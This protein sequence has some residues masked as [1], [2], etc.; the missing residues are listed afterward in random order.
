MIRTSVR[1]IAELV[2]ALGAVEGDRILIHSAVFAFGLIEDGLAG[3]HRGI[4]SVVGAE[5]TIIVPTFTWSFRRGE[6]F[7]I[8]NSP[9]AKSVGAYSEWLRNVPGSVR[10]ACPLFSMAALGPDASRLMARTSSNCFGSGSVYER[11]FADDVLVLGLGITYSTGIS[12][13]MHLERVAYV[14]YRQELPLEGTSIDATGRPYAD[15]AVHFA[16][17][18]VRFGGYRTDREAVGARMEAAGVSAMVRR[19]G[20]SFIGLRAQPFE[21]FVLEELRRDPFAMLAVR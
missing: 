8:R 3:L 7:D 5:G 19:N 20:H 18:E 2:R 10:S 14:P 17:D 21:V 15:R 4:A 1:E 11:L 6:V 16:R 12:P 13:F 9:A